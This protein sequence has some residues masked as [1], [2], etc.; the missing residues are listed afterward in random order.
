MFAEFEE[1]P[2]SDEEEDHFDFEQFQFVSQGHLI[3]VF[4]WK[5]LHW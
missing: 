2:D 5:I 4:F 3:A 1:E